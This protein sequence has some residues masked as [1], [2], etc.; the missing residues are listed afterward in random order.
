MLNN[1]SGGL[2]AGIGVVILFF[3]VI[4]LLGNIE[5]Y[6]NG[7][8][9]VVEHRSWVRKFSDYLAIMV[10]CPVLMIVASSMNVFI[11]G[12]LSQVA[13]EVELV[14]VMEP[15]IKFGLKLSPFIV[16]WLL[17][18][19]IYTVIPNTRV[20]ILSGFVG[21]VAGGTIFQIFQLIYINVM[22]GML[23]NSAVY[24][25]FAALPLF[26]LWLQISWQILLFGAEVSFA[27]QN[28]ETYGYEPDSLNASDRFR[29]LSALR[30]VNVVV[31]AFVNGKGPVSES[32]INEG[33]EIPTRLLKELLHKLEEAT[34]LIEVKGDGESRMRFFAPAK[35]SDSL[36][37]GSVLNALELRGKTDIPIL[38]CPE[39][40][41]LREA[42]EQFHSGNSYE[43]LQIPLK[44]I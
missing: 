31:K 28:V 27:Y 37:I 8:W 15:F 14:G 7:I 10:V 29:K 24:G 13:E 40:P 6:L 25:G 21:G 44:S 41:K 26:L 3:T 32:E 34:I 1:T 16:L 35:D 18:S 33:L 9:G 20:K 38:D 5:L 12:Q 11:I 42:L 23:S 30:I 43:S 22:A 17:F 36:T 39:I 4:R 19:F 2:I